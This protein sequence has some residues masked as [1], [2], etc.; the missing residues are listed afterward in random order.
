MLQLKDRVDY[1]MYFYEH[2]PKEALILDEA[3]NI[4]I[5][6]K[7]IVGWIATIEEQLVK[8]NLGSKE[9]LKEVLI[10]AILPNVFQAQ[11]K[12]VLMKSKNVFAWSHKE[13]KGIPR[14]VCEHKIELM[15]DA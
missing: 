7:N 13:L 8:L 12:K 1:L 6:D 11:I 15:V 14:E 10:N 9:E 4:T 5:K 2:Q 3:V